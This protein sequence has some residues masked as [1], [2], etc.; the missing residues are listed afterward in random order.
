MNTPT[1]CEYCR[2]WRYETDNVCCC[3]ESGHFCE[4]VSGDDF[5]DEFWE[6]DDGQK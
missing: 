1:I 2:Y 5:C 3:P 4:T 6:E